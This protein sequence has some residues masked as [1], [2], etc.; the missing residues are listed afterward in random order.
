MVETACEMRKNRL[1]AELADL[2]DQVQAAFVK[3]N[4]DGQT[5]PDIAF[6]DFIGLKIGC[7]HKDGGQ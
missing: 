6:G 7:Y 5:N 4:Q 2:S 3:A 1:R